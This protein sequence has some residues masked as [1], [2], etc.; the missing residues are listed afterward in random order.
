[1]ANFKHHLGQ[2]DNLDA[3]AHRKSFVAAVNGIF[4]GWL[5][6]FTGDVKTFGNRWRAAALDFNRPKLARAKIN[7]QINF[8]TALGSIKPDS[9]MFKKGVILSSHNLPSYRRLPDDPADHR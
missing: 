3:A 1:M 9:G 4:L 5:K 8:G 6:I 7:Y 2:A